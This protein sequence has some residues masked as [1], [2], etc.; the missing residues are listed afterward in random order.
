MSMRE[1]G[2]P[3]RPAPEDPGRL[4]PDQPVWEVDGEQRGA[5][6]GHAARPQRALVPE[7]VRRARL[8]V[9]PAAAA[10]ALPGG[11]SQPPGWPQGQPR[12]SGRGRHLLAAA[13]ALGLFAAG[14][15]VGSM[16]TD[17]ARD[18]ARPA[19]AAPTTS[20]MPTTAAPTTT[21]PPRAVSPAACLSAVDEA[22]AAISYLVT[23]VRDQR[24]A[25]TMQRYRAAS[26]VCRRAR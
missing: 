13:L 3:V 7:S 17:G 5:E 20:G 1:S 6:E 21:A 14:T 9:D 12:R 18:P 26:R 15:A 22:D 19:R 16:L 24:L 10:E 8:A 23:N 4:S 2:R 25:R 11:A